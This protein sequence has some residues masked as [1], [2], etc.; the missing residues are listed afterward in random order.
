MRWA[1]GFLLVLGLNLFLLDVYNGESPAGPAAEP[2]DSR[3]YAPGSLV[4][5]SCVPACA[6]GRDS[7]GPAPGPPTG[8]NRNSV[9]T[10]ASSSACRS[11]VPNKEGRRQDT[12]SG[13]EHLIL[14]QT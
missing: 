11:P 3:V 12:K 10:T 1:A 7:P 2:V 9:G 8:M 13:I 14:A 6:A 5:T 4:P